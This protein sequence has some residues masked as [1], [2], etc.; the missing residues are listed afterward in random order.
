MH[1]V[2][3]EQD[4]AETPV[5]CFKPTS[6]QVIRRG[7][8]AELIDV[9]SDQSNGRRERHAARARLLRLGECCDQCCGEAITGIGRLRF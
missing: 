9:L 1:I 4:L 7:V 2:N 5:K 8:E 6:Q 3:A